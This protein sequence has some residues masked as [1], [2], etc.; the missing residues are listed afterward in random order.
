M[1]GSNNRAFTGKT[2][3]GFPNMFLAIRDTGF[4]G[5]IRV[6]SIHRMYA[7]WR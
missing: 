4:T 5:D 2:D 3:L 7:G 1:R 6:A